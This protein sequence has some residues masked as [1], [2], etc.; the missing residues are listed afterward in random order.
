[1][2]DGIL[3]EIFGI[4]NIKGLELKGTNYVSIPDLPEENFGLNLVKSKEFVLT[5]WELGT[6][7]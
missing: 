3:V 5:E 2:D 7:L 4:M 1:M 6:T